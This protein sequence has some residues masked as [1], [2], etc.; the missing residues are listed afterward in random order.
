MKVRTVALASLGF[1]HISSSFGQETYWED[2][3][4]DAAGTRGSEL[5]IDL[6][7]VPTVGVKNRRPPCTATREDEENAI[8]CSVSNK[9][10]NALEMDQMVTGETG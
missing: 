3:R 5:E 8:G 6:A 9:I 10:F 2:R 7:T 4:K 1:I